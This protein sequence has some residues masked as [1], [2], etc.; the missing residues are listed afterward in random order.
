M[1]PR[2][3]VFLAVAAATITAAAAYRFFPSTEGA[4]P[5]VALYEVVEEDFHRQVVAHG[6]LKAV[7]AAQISP[8]RVPGHRG[9]VK[10]AWLAEDGSEV[11]KGDVVLRISPIE[12]EQKLLD[13]RADLAAAEARLAKTRTM[14]KVT[15][16]SRES[17]ATIAQIELENTQRFSPKNADVFSRHE[18]IEGAIDEELSQE[19]V[20]HARE[21]NTIQ[22]RISQSQLGE[23]QVQKKAAQLAI[24]QAEAGL[25]SLVVRAP[26]AGIVVLER[27][28]QGRLPQIGQSVWPGQTVAEIPILQKMEAEVFVLEVDGG[29][30]TEGLAASVVL[31]SATSKSYRGKVKRIA[32]LAKPRTQDVPVQYFA[33][34]VSLDATDPAV[35]KP[36]TRVTATLTLDIGNALVIPRQAVFY[37]DD[38]ATI[39]RLAGDGFEAVSVKLGA[40]TP[41]RVVVTEGLQAGDRIALRAPT[42][43]DTTEGE[44]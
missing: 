34:T 11:K 26:H 31:E 3:M 23:I 9:P 36:G 10:I 12:L 6:N 19:K 39:Y 1:K 27:D 20:E 24:K 28:W 16:G 15:Q 33:V 40:E 4:A 25:E 35:M 7:K 37:R 22:R 42:G 2:T 21:A 41:G 32:K 13:G 30:L 5:D 8:P 38:V 29:G 18:I 17:T 43:A 14:A 44:S